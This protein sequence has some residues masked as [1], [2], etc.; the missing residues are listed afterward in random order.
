MAA[1]AS[2]SVENMPTD[3]GARNAEAPAAMIVNG[4]GLDRNSA[5]YSVRENAY[6]ILPHRSWRL[7]A[8]L[9]E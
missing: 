7:R 9:S 8:W 5:A 4:S 3:S 1:T 6:R 2:V